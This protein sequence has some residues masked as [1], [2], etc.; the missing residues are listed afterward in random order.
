M[1]VT[2]DEI[3]EACTELLGK[4]EMRKRRGGKYERVFITA[5]QIWTLLRE[6]KNPICQTLESEYGTAVGK[7][8]GEH[9]GPAQRI[10]VAL[11]SSGQIETYHLDVRRIELPGVKPSGSSCGIFRLRE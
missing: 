5:Y 11:E 1:S 9:V 3:V 6:E 7:G 4:V 10:G 2:K 8:G